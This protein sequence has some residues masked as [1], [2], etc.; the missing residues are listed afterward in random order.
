MIGQEPTYWVFRHNNDTYSRDSVLIPYK[1]VGFE[2]WTY[3]QDRTYTI[4][5]IVSGGTSGV[6][7]TVW[8]AVQDYPSYN[9]PLIS[10]DEE[11]RL[12][13]LEGLDASY[14]GVHTVNMQVD[15]TFFVNFLTPLT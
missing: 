8:P 13:K 3:C 12:F 6:S 10:L 1:P 9:V 14:A 4:T 2:G 7:G 15:L 11:H 5:S